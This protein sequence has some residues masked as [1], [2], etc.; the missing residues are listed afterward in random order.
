[1]RKADPA[2]DATVNMLGN[3]PNSR[4]RLQRC[5]SG[6]RLACIAMLLFSGA[7]RAQPLSCGAMTPVTVD[8][9]GAV[10]EAFG[11]SEQ[12]VARG[13]NRGPAWEWAVGPDSDE[14][15][16][17]R[18]S[19]D[20]VSGRIY[21]WRATYGASGNL[22]LQVNDQ[23]RTVLNLV[24][25]S[26]M[27]TGNSL[28]LAVMTHGAA[29]RKVGMRATLT[30]I[31]GMTV[32]G[33]DVTRTG[34]RTAMRAGGRTGDS[35]GRDDEADYDEDGDT[36]RTSSVMVF[37]P[38]M[39]AGFVAEGTVSLVYDRLPTGGRVTMRVQAG[40]IPCA[41]A[42][43]PPAVAITTPAAGQVFASPATVLLSASAADPDGTIARVDF[44]HG[45][46]LIGTATTA[47]FTIAWAPVVAGSYSVTAVATDNQ[48]ATKVSDP[49]PIRV[50]APPAVSILSPVANTSFDASAAVAVAVQAS[51]PDGSVQR[52][53]L[54]ANGS[55]IA[56]LTG[57]PYTYNWTGVAAG[58]YDLIATAVDSNDAR[59]EST[60]IRI[61]VRAARALHFIH[62]DHLNTP[63]LVADANQ[64]TVWKWEQD[65]PFGDNVPIGD[66]DQDAVS[67]DFPPRFPGQYA[68]RETGLYYNYYRDY[69]ARMGRYL[70]SDPIG[71]AGGINTYAYVDSNPLTYAD[72]LGL[73]EI[74]VSDPGSRS[75]PTYGGRITVTGESGQTVTV[76]G[77]SW[78]NPANPSPGIQ[79][80]TYPGVYSPTGHQGR[81]PGVRL[82][83]GGKVPTLGPNPAQ[84]NQP[85]ATGVN[86]HCGFRADRRGSAGCITVDPA[87]CQQVWSV[88]RAGETGSITI[89]R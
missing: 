85:L 89:R 51:D 48:G 54:R 24:Y 74:L 67:F 58:T 45:A 31:N 53:E 46:N 39:R 11:A 2:D 70:E 69:D 63:R 18:G 33:A 30:A 66:P 84:G 50:N 86:L 25:P 13:G 59:T 80:G 64:K 83:N 4:K 60:A 68:D 62:V 10:F 42:N 37:Y 15:R 27:R 12:I 29:V 76:P 71:L 79:P 73:F 72:P 36:R 56:T 77:S 7:I 78:P 20:W 5:G 61:T 43:S 28:R 23:A 1:M 49:V 21:R 44:F 55:P 8:R 34:G 17:V 65:E 82:R 38:P 32:A 9:P 87:Y 14:D 52:V 57:A 88:L 41:G 22:A 26:G 3:A 6:V 47:P 19:L 16:A 75:G 35:E 40:N 81:H